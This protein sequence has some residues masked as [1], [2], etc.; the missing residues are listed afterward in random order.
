MRYLFVLIFLFSNFYG[1]A[2][3]AADKTIDK[4]AKVTDPIPPDKPPSKP[5]KDPRSAIFQSSDILT[6]VKSDK[7]TTKFSVSPKGIYALVGDSKVKH[8]EISTELVV[9]NIYKSK[10]QL[11]LANSHME[12]T[13]ILVMSDVLKKKDALKYGSDKI[14][15]AALFAIKDYDKNKTIDLKKFEV[16]SQEN[17]DKSHAP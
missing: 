8:E 13:K 3:D 7:I 17:M 11:K 4:D 16:L 14:G 5:K 15:E 2:L 12:R 6:V 9:L 10:D 1:A